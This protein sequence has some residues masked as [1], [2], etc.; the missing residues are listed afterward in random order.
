MKFALPMGLDSKMFAPLAVTFVIGTFFISTTATQEP[1]EPCEEFVTNAESQYELVATSHA[2]YSDDRPKEMKKLRAG[3]ANNA[4][5]C[6]QHAPTMVLMATIS[7]ESYDN[8]KALKY[9]KLAVKADPNSAAANERLGGVLTLYGLFDTGIPHLEKAARL[10][11]TQPQYVVS[12]CSNYEMAGRYQEAV[13]ACSEAFSMLTT[14]AER[15]PAH[16]VRARA[17][18]RLGMTIEAGRDFE[19]AKQAGFDGAW[20]YSD[21]H[22]G[23]R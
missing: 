22:L 14:P 2:P 13:T 5:K 23:R 11:P 18:T 16:Y 9:A 4:S 3:L 10:D 8:S 20:F 12:L 6:R 17:Y 1:S 7:L 19:A 21:E 15:A